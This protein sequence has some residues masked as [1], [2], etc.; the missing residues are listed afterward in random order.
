MGRREYYFVEHGDAMN[1]EG[2]KELVDRCDRLAK[3]A[4]PFTEKRLL[5][6]AKTYRAR[7]VEMEKA[8]SLSAVS[9]GSPR[10]GKK[11]VVNSSPT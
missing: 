4:D 6:L 2:L 1:I 9:E 11:C 10:R 7:I 8:L 5:G 3:D